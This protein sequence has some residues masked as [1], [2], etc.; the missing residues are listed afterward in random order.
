MRHIYTNT[1]READALSDEELKARI[2]YLKKSP[3]LG[4]WG[5]RELSIAQAEATTREIKRR[6]G[7]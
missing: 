3:H 5:Q 2:A 1:T 4:T 7:K 6:G